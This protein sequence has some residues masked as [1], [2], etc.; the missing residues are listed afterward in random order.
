MESNYCQ[1]VTESLNSQR[2]ID[3]KTFASIEVLQ[4]RL[5]RLKKLSGSFGEI[6]FSPEFK[7][8][9]RK[10]SSTTS[11]PAFLLECDWRWST[12]RSLG[13]AW[14]RHAATDLTPPDYL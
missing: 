6:E 11:R 9:S 1:I 2:G 7:K 8:L 3:E 12:R 10:A 13:R 4:D 14:P 5:D